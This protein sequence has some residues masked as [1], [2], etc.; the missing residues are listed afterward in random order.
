M[1]E[2]WGLLTQCLLDGAAGG[3]EQLQ[4]CLHDGAAA[5]AIVV[6]EGAA[7]AVNSQGEGILLR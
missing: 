3:E 6:V 2:D 4:V 5:E 7:G 1:E